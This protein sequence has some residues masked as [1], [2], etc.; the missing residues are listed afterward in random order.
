MADATNEIDD[1]D[2]GSGKGED[3]KVPEP[4]EGG[5]DYIRPGFYKGKIVE[6]TMGMTTPQDG[7]PPK[8]K[9]DL[10]VEVQ[11]E[12]AKG[13][14]LKKTVAYTGKMKN[15]APQIKQLFEVMYACGVK[16]E[17]IQE[18]ADAGKKWKPAQMAKF[19]LEKPCF[20]E[21]NDRQGDGQ[22]AGRTFSDLSNWVAPDRFNKVPEGLRRKQP[23]APATAAGAAASIY[24]TAAAGNGSAATAKAAKA[25]P[26]AAPAAEEDLE[27]LLQ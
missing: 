21:V 11:D 16:P 10:V 8:S 15:G 26:I 13:A 23:S 7:K 5:S 9:F 22:Y 2:F 19:L 14:K 1:I 3:G 20:I 12:D 6:V 18:Y 25:A 4:Y 24:G 17:K 27:S